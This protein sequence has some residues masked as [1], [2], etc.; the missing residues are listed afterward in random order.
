MRLP[1]RQGY[2]AV[3]TDTRKVQQQ[4]GQHAL[5]L[6]RCFIEEKDEAKKEEFLQDLQNCIQILATRPEK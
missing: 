2:F 4:I 3:D 6:M 5:N 1:A